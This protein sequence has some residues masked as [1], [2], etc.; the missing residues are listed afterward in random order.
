MNLL[1]N[2]VAIIPDEVESKTASGII[3]PE[4]AKEKPKKG[5]VKYV[6]PG[7]N[8]E[9]MSVKVGDK[10]LYGKYAGTEMEYQGENFLMCRETDI[11]A[12]INEE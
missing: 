4:T 11:F 2:R 3:I 10:V 6:G 8:K 7:I 5:T 12:T 1:E 9:P